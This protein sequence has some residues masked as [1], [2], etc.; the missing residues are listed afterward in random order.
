MDEKAGA[1]TAVHKIELRKSPCMEN[2]TPCAR[3][4]VGKISEV[5][6]N[7]AASMPIVYLRGH[8]VRDTN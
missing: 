6:T 4:S 7:A 3:S 1:A 2:A 5:Y 8:K